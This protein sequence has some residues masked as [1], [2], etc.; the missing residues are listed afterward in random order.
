MRAEP[1]GPFGIDDAAL[2][3]TSESGNTGASRVG[4]CQV[5]V[6]FYSAFSFDQG[7]VK[8]PPKKLGPS[9]YHMRLSIGFVE[10]NRTPRGFDRVAPACLE[11]GAPQKKKI[12]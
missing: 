1:N 10:L 11:V 9:Q 3:V 12:D 6:D 5:R 7:N 4:A 8:T 2:R